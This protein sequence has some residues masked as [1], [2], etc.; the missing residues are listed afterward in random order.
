VS[1]SVPWRSA[2]KTAASHAANFPG[3]GGPL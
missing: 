2:A 3:L 1:K